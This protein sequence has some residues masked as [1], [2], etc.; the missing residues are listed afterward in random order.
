MVRPILLPKN[1]SDEKISAVSIS[2][3]VH[4]ITSV[5]N[6]LNFIWFSLLSKYPSFIFCLKFSY[7]VLRMTKEGV[8]SKNFSSNPQFPHQF[9]VSLIH[10]SILSQLRWNP[11]YKLPNETGIEFCL[12]IYVGTK[13]TNNNSIPCR[14]SFIN[15]Y[16]P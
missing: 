1:Y 11:F 5:K 8:S 13:A 6:I 4:T 16:M 14:I 2:A 9:N 12:I 7:F 3:D 10:V 15:D